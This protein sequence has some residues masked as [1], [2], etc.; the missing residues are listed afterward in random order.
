MLR[1]RSAS[2]PPLLVTLLALAACGGGEDPV[3]PDPERPPDLTGSYTLQSLSAIV[4]GG[5]TLTSPDVS[6]SFSVQQTAVTGAEASGTTMIS[7]TLPDG[8]GGTATL[9]DQGTYVNRLDGTWEQ[10]G[11]LLQGLGTYTLQ[12]DVLTVEV[13]EPALN[14]STTV[15]RKD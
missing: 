12:G 13:T 8:L 4:T 11:L 3:T 7:I 1:S 5:Q 2:L 10:A 14:V 9:E 15:W 6:G